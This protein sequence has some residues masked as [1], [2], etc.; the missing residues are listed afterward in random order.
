MHDHTKAAL[1]S[2][3]SQAEKAAAGARMH[4]I[5]VRVS[6]LK[7]SDLPESPECLGCRLIARLTETDR[8]WTNSITAIADQFEAEL[9]EVAP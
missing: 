2:M 7:K 3:V 5:I 6:M 4:A 9:R 8:A 1:D